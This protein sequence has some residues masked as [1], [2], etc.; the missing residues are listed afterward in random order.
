MRLSTPAQSSDLHSLAR[1][2][3]PYHS[4]L[5]T[6]CVGAALAGLAFVIEAAFNFLSLSARMLGVPGQN[7]LRAPYPFYLLAV[8]AMQW[9]AIWLLTTEDPSPLPPRRIRTWL[10]RLLATSSLLIVFMYVLRMLE[11]WRFRTTNV[12]LALNAIELFTTI[13]FWTHLRSVARKLDMHGSRWRALVAMIG[14]AL[15]LIV[16]FIGPRSS[17]EFRI[18]VAS[19]SV[20]LPNARWASTVLWAVVSALVM[21]RFALGFANEV[22]QDRKF[23]AV[24]RS[25]QP[26]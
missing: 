13:L 22:R 15:T 9:I 3:N 14:T 11:A 16:L 7:M 12:F 6:L 24:D 25:E 1:A 18:I 21:L 19:G 5:N 10:L 23:R 26:A 2:G 8:A 17:N 4:W 20:S